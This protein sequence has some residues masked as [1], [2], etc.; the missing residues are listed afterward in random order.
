MNFVSTKNLYFKDDKF[1]I[2][3]YLASIV[4]DTFKVLD[5]IEIL[6]ITTKPVATLSTKIFA[7]IMHIASLPFSDT[8]TLRYSSFIL[9]P[10]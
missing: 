7:I 10:K 3:L 8:N 5:F 1:Q 9:V 2:V 4:T 6:F